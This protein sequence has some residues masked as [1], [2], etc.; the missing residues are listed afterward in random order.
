MGLMMG[1]ELE[2]ELAGPLLTK[3][4]Y[5]ND[6][7]MVYANNDTSVCQLLPPLVMDVEQVDWVA[8]RLD[9]ALAAAR[10]LKPLLKIKRRLGNIIGK[11]AP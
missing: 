9:R 7:L 4:A 3:T 6:L 1:L 8:Q 5:D 11:I 2:D 10:R